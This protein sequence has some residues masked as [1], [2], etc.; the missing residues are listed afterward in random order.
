MDVKILDQKN[1]TIAQQTQK[2]I[3]KVL[4]LIPFRLDVGELN[5]QKSSFNSLGNLDVQNVNI[6]IKNVS[7]KVEEHLLVEEL[8]LNNPEF[9]NIP[10]KEPKKQKTNTNQ[11]K[12]LVLIIKIKIN[13]AENKLKNKKETYIKLTSNE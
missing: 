13:N 8:Q 5:I 3:E 12:D 7:N 6:Q 11:L 2:D 10:S 4:P 1:E 9:I